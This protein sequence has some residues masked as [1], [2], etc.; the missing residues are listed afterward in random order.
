VLRQ[1]GGR[2]VL[3]IWIGPTEAQSI[4]LHLEG[5]VP[6]RP[7]THDLLSGMLFSLKVQVVRIVIHDLQEN[8]FYAS[9][10]LR[11]G[12]NVCEVDSRPSDAIALAVRMKAPIFVAGS[13]IEAMVEEPTQEE[14]EEVAKFRKL[15]EDVEFSADAPEED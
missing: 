3:H 15:I 8:T 2:R 11:H 4:A 13:A 9:I 6:E 1:P 7:W 5:K 10:H 14:R 12:N